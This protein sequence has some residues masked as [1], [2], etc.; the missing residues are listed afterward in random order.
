LFRLLV[1]VRRQFDQRT[2]HGEF[3]SVVLTL[4]RLVKIVQRLLAKPIRIEQACL[5]EF[6]RKTL[7][8]YSAARRNG[9]RAELIC[10]SERVTAVAAGRGT[11]C[12]LA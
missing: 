12:R 7:S 3:V 10:Y 9:N 5:C 4:Y 11:T 6:P 2:L 1:E 8:T